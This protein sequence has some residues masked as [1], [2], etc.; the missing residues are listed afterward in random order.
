MSRS[1]TQ[2]QPKQIVGLI[3]DGKDEGWY[4]NAL[5]DHLHSDRLKRSNLKP[6]L[7]SKKKIKELF[8]I[9]ERMIKNDGYDKVFL[10]VDL[11]EPLKEKQEGKGEELEMFKTWY[12]RYMQAQQQTPYKGKHKW[13]QQLTIVVNNP[14]LEYWHLLHFK[15]T[16]KYFPNYEDLLTDLKRYLPEYDKSEKYYLAKPNNIFD[17]LGK[18]EGLSKAVSNAGLLG[19]FD[20]NNCTSTGMTEMDEIINYFR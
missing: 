19:D 3:V 18:E 16:N 7:P 15:Q 12:S 20:V 1:K 8:G 6:E 5:K 17:K 9:A 4:L 2:R 13:M 11:D 14:C 10:I